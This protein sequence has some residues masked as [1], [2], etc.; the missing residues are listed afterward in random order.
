M[1]PTPTFSAIPDQV[2]EKIVNVL[3]DFIHIIDRDYRIIY[4]NTAFIALNQSYGLESNL[5]GKNWREVFA[6]LPVKVFNQYEEIFRTGQELITKDRN[7]INKKLM[8]TQTTKLPVK[9]AGEVKYII[10]IMKDITEQQSTGEIIAHSTKFKSLLLSISATMMESNIVNEDMIIK[11]AL[12]NVAVFLNADRSYIF[13]MSDTKAEFNLTHEYY[14][15]EIKKG[16]Q[17]QK[18]Y[19]KEDYPWFW[20]NLSKE[21]ATIIDNINKFPLDAQ[22]EREKFLKQGIQ[23]MICLTLIQ[24]GQIIGFFGLDSIG[25]E[26]DWNP[27]EIIDLRLFADIFTNFLMHNQAERELKKERE[28]LEAAND[29]LKTLIEGSPL[30]IVL[31]DSHAKVVK[32]NPAATHIFGF[33]ESEAIGKFL[34]TIPEDQKEQFKA[35]RKRILKGEAPSYEAQRIRKDGKR[36][37][38]YVSTTTLRDKNNDITFIMG[39]IEDI[40]EK[41]KAAETKQHL[42]QQLLQAQKM[43]SIG[44]L[45]GG[46]AHDFNNMLTTILG[47]ISL[48]KDESG[49]ANSVK[50]ALIEIEQAAQKAAALTRQLLA[51]SRKQVIQSKNSNLNE[52]IQRIE[53]MLLRLIG[54]DITFTAKY[55]PGLLPILVDP[56]QIEQM[57]VN[58]AI[59]ARD[60][61]PHG[62][63]LLLETRQITLYRKLST[64]Y[65][66][67]EPGRY[68]MLLVVDNGEGMTEDVKANLFEP[69]FTTKPKG[70]GTGL[71]LAMVY[72]TIKQNEG[73]IQV[74][75]E[76]QKGTTYRIYFPSNTST[77]TISEDKVIDQ[78]TIR[79]KV[80]II[81]VEDDNALRKLTQKMLEQMGYH[82]FAFEDG[83]HALKGVEKIHYPIDLLITDVIMPGMNGRE[84]AEKIQNKRP[85]IEI[86]YISG[87]TEDVLGNHGVLDKETHFLAK[88]FSIDELQKKIQEILTVEEGGD[89]DKEVVF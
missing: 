15:A 79:E 5:I 69:F 62:G 46:V 76:I 78:T 44:R 87:Y 45:A 48:V 30:A 35:I 19:P 60:A 49:L 27:D 59:N 11:D 86:L 6:I 41:K 77:M 7:E 67:L 47:N 4:A 52:I 89:S 9:I 28:S 14:T 70:K 42:E 75:S 74:H 66:T 56:N 61:M 23:S 10:T 25:Q 43:E 24:Q 13:K 83:P 81:F 53:K 71:G 57:I 16:F 29:E 51:F 72:G 85:E 38:V 58:L 26:R 12:A 68:T 17:F 80:S 20:A 82:V 63:R 3:G 40:T 33:S 31:I 32:W 18:N 55:D 36:I 39:I 50:E 8:H 73:A 84:L 65:D 88:P 1:Q 21:Q 34:P 22:R 37:D 2:L 54:E 64:Y